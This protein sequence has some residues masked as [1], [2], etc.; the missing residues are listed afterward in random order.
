MPLLLGRSL[1]PAVKLLGS[2]LAY[3]PPILTTVVVNRDVRR[4]LRHYSR[5]V[6]I[7]RF[8]CRKHEHSDVN[9]R[10]HSDDNVHEAADVI[11]VSPG[12]SHLGIPS[13]GNSTRTVPAHAEIDE[14]SALAGCRRRSHAAKPRG[15]P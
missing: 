10:Y 2:R 4:A 3:Q 15:P 12:G 7:T 5:F 8:H 6:V 11:W 1:N 13:S 14:P 9:L